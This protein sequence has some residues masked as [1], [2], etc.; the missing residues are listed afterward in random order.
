MNFKS[1]ERQRAES[2]GGGRGWRCEDERNRGRRGREGLNF[3]PRVTEFTDICTR[4]RL[5]VPHSF[6]ETTLSLLSIPKT[7]SSSYI[8]RRMK[9]FTVLRAEKEKNT[10]KQNRIECVGFE[11][12]LC[13]NLQPHM[14]PRFFSYIVCILMEELTRGEEKNDMWQAIHLSCQHVIFTTFKPHVNRSYSLTGEGDLGRNRL[15]HPDT[16]GECMEIPQWEQPM[17]EIGENE[18]QVRAEGQVGKRKKSQSN[19]L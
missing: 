10:E 7:Y 14:S 12:C 2:E 5:A 9:P 1:S 11:W 19:I 15:T 6:S 17:R 13:D 18:R 3:N 16:A 4:I 8:R